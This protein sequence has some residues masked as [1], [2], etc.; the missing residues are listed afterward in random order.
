MA[1]RDRESLEDF[2]ERNITKMEADIVA[3]NFRKLN[4][5]LLPDLAIDEEE[6]EFTGNDS[7]LY[8]YQ[9]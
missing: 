5:S 1:K 2:I 7:G 8:Q 4:N 9:Q 6:E 3:D